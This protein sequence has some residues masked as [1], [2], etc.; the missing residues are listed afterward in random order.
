MTAHSL[1][2]IV[3]SQSGAYIH[4]YTASVQRIIALNLGMLGIMPSWDID[5]TSL[6]AHSWYE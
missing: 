1:P 2:C 6:L 4:V 5:T 3:T